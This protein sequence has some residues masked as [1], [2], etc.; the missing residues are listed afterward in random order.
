MDND[1][2][3]LKDEARR[4]ANKNRLNEFVKYGHVGAALMTDKGNIYWRCNYLCL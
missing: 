4:L 2:I 1:F 3:L